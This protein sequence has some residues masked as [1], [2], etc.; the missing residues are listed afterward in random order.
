MANEIKQLSLYHFQACPYC[1]RTRKAL[2]EMG[3]HIE[4]KDI[5][6]Q[7]SFRA[8]LLKQGGKLQVPC[9]RIEKAKG[10]VEWLYESEQIIR[11]LREINVASKQVA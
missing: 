8:E 10:Q 11:Y 9:L 7:H 1:E 4:L 2:S 3:L 6:K 5:R